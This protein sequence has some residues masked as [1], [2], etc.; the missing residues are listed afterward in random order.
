MPNGSNLD[1]YLDAVVREVTV[2]ENGRATGVAYINREDMKE[3]TIKGKVVVLAAS[4]ASSARILL[5]SK[6]SAHPNGLAN[7]SEHVGRYIHD[8]TGAGMRS[9]ERRVGI[10]YSAR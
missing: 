9:E 5:N 7:S 10:E 8:S 4:A 3:Y 2:D 1:L 6:S